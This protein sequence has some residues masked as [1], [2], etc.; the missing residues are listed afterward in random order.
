MSIIR[1]PRHQTPQ[2]EGPRIS[3][4]T[5]RLGD[6]PAWASVRGES[7]AFLASF[8][9]SWATDELTRPAYR[10]RLRAYQKD[11][12]TDMGYAFFI[13]DK[14]SEALLGG[15]RISNVRRGVAQACSLG[16]WMGVQHAGKGYMGEAVR[17][18]IPYVFVHLKLHRLEAACVPENERSMRLLKSAGFR[19][20]GLARNYLRIA[21]EWRDH[22]L[23]ALLAEDVA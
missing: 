14:E 2:L 21:G 10:R 22:V 8:E 13:F 12:R 15:A 11:A 1:S 18:L 20:E 16:Y 19:E 4:R 6:Y 7:R 5:P 3:L 9:P 17:A 23:F